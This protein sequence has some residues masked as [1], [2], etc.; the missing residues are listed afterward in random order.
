MTSPVLLLITCWSLV[1][2]DIGYLPKMKTLLSRVA[3]LNSVLGEGS[4]AVVRVLQ[5]VSSNTNIS[6]ESMRTLL[7]LGWIA[8]PVTSKTC[9]DVYIV[10]RIKQK[11]SYRLSISIDKGRAGMPISSLFHVGQVTNKSCLGVL[12]HSL[13][14]PVIFRAFISACHYIMVTHLH[15]TG[16]PA[17]YNYIL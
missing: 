1:N 7:P 5:S 6:V 15:T 16:I 8:P 9:N 12:S 2:G 3:A 13:Q 17:K 4:L 11:Y 10:I 14:G